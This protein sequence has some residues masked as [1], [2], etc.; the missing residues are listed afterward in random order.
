MSAKIASVGSWCHTLLLARAAVPWQ[1]AASKSTACDDPYFKLFKLVL[2]P[3]SKQHQQQQQ[4]RASDSAATAE[5]GASGGSVAG[6]L[7]ASHNA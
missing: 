3:K 2:K 4:G 6:G 7:L 1:S 5:S